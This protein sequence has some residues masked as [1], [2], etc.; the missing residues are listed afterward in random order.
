MPLIVQPFLWV[1]GV[2][3]SNIAGMDLVRDT[4]TCKAASRLPEHPLYGFADCVGTMQLD[5]STS[6]GIEHNVVRFG[7]RLKA[8]ISPNVSPAKS[9]PGRLMPYEQ[10][11]RHTV[12]AERGTPKVKR[13]P[14]NP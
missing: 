12:T 10:A 14:S 8:L 6:R 3:G 1:E 2:H 13:R 9:C 4:V 11:T 5:R 7:M